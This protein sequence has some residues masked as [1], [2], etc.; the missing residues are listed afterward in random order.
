MKVLAVGAHP[1]DVELGCGAALLAHRARG[2]DV[3]LLVLTG[4][5]HGPQG[6]SSR[7]SEQEIAASI[8][9][10]ELFWGGFEDGA[11]PEGRAAVAAVEEAIRA[12]GADVVYT[13]SPRDSHQD[14]RSA[15]V[16]T[17]AAG[18]HVSR[19]LMYETPSSL[20]FA[21]TVFVDAAEHL[22]GKLKA[23]RAHVS[24]VLQNQMVDLDAVAAQARFRGFQ[25]RLRHAEGFETERFAWDLS[26]LPRVAPGADRT[27]TDVEYAPSGRR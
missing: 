17:L 11:V 25:A 27:V 26:G 21:P 18:R 7:V 3:G 13:H 5:E 22:T 12:T 14:H 6:Q 16:A 9:G 2:D 4:G 20:G 15:A 8:L 19:I 24:Q 1:D 23:L 10:A